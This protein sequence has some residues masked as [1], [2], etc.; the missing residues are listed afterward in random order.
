MYNNCMNII[1]RLEGK[2]V[3]SVQAMPAEPL[4][5]EDCINAMMKSVVKG[6]AGALRVAGARDVRNAKS[7]ICRMW[8]VVFKY[9]NG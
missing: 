6:G 5:Q 9:R 4:Y 1:N 2:V 7:S 8:S 3:V